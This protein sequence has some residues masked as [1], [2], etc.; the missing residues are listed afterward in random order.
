MERYRENTKYFLPFCMWFLRFQ[1]RSIIELPF[2]LVQLFKLSKNRS[3]HLQS[4]HNKGRT[5]VN[6]DDLLLPLS[7]QAWHGWVMGGHRQLC[8]HDCIVKGHYPEGGVT[9]G[10]ESSSSDTRNYKQFHSSA[11]AAQA[12]NSSSS[13]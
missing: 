8:E 11:G 3:Y 6:P 9:G 10:C 4:E 1:P 5:I 13:V 12:G 2:S 7:V